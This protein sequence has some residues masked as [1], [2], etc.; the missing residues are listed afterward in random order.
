MPFNP[1]DHPVCFDAPQ[2]VVASPWNHH[3]PVGLLLTDLLRP[4]VVV[5]LGASDGV[6]LAAFCQAASALRLEMRCLVAASTL[7]AHARAYLSDHF[8]GSATLRSSPLTPDDDALAEGGI[9]L[10]HLADPGDTD[11]ITTLDAWLPKL[12]A[13]GVLLIDGAAPAW[14]AALRRYPQ[15]KTTTTL[16][17]ELDIVSVVALGDAPLAG[18]RALADLSPEEL[19][20][21]RALLW[22]LGESATQRAEATA[23]TATLHHERKQGAAQA[24]LLEGQQRELSETT[25][26]L[27]NALWQMEW[28]GKSR[29]VRMVKLARASRAVLR[30]RGPVWL[31]RRVALWT[32]GQRGYYRLDSAAAQPAPKLPR[33]AEREF[34][35]VMFLS[36]CPGGAMRYRCDHQAEQLNLLG[37]SAESAAVS[38]VNLMELLDRFQCF[39]LHRVAYDADMQAF[40]AEARTRGK[41]LFFETD[42][43]VFAPGSA[44]NERNQAELERF[45]PQERTLYIDEM[46]RIRQTAQLCDAATVSTEPLRG[47]VSPL[48]SPVAVTP[49]VASQ[50]MIVRSQMALDE[51]VE[52]GEATAEAGGRDATADEVIIAYLSGSPSHDRDF[53]E[54]QDAVL[55]ALETYPQARLLVVGPLALSAR[56]DRFGARVQR[57]ALRPWQALSATYASVDINLAPLERDNPFTEAKSSIKFLEAAL[58]KVPTIASPRPDFIRVVRD[59]ENGLLADTSDAWRAALRRLIESPEERR[60]LG[61]AASADALALHTTRAQAPLVCETLRAHYRAVAPADPARRLRV[62]WMV[63]APA[64]ARP[65]TLGLARA[66]AERGHSVRICVAPFA[67]PSEGQPLPAWQAEAPPAEVV[68]TP[69]DGALPA[70]EAS[71]ATSRATA[72]LVAQQH[73]SLFRFQLTSAPDADPD[74][75]QA[76][77]RRLCVEDAGDPAAQ[78]ERLEG[79]LSEWVW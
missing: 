39:V 65:P 36:G 49:N 64:A 69:G 7:P 10:L 20:A 72:Q 33:P 63:D 24:L 2:Y 1:L 18:I 28:L 52:S 73:E 61:E 21:L 14:D 40:M 62:N 54:A 74:E 22:A 31:A 3:I 75:T 26:R 37:C 79:L 78:A 58:L 48:C 44:G 53:L 5:E 34:K 43:L 57:E 67:A 32:L 66:L 6:A 17:S 23:L 68:M 56:F 41:P 35:Q 27:D 11:T 51:L 30:Q 59:G 12:S 19:D 15:R 42:D 47:W 50:E 70:A 16:G 77:L 71:V 25:R 4:R 13:G 45:T 60:R 38:T 9:D 8:S 46:E 29:G 55:W 76:P